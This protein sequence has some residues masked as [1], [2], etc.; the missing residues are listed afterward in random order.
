MVEEA[1][2]IDLPIEEPVEFDSLDEDLVLTILGLIDD[3]VTLVRGL[4]V[5]KRW[6]ARQII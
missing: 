1:V 3:R 4:L 2:E 5:C 6:A